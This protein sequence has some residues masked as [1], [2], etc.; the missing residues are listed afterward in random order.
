MSSLKYVRLYSGPD[1]ESHF[2][3]VELELSDSGRGTDVSVEFP[4]SSVNFANF[5]DDYGFDQHTA[6]RDRFVVMLTGAIEVETSDGEV[7]TLG[8]G[9]VLRAEDLTGVGHKSRVVGSGE[10][11][12]MYVQVPTQLDRLQ[13]AQREL[14]RGHGGSL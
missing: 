13:D 8:P 10:R 12:A 5:R 7:R 14:G 3:D 4:A 6:P 1:G 9:T 11:L 2:E